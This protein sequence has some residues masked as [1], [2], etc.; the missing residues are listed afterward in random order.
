MEIPAPISLLYTM[1]T[2]SREQG[3]THLPR[4]NWLMASLFVRDEPSLLYIDQHAD[5]VVDRRCII[6]TGR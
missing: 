1:W 3:I 5:F 4:A 6:S 2:V